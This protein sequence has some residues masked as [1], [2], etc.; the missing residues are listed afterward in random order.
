VFL[1][2]GIIVCWIKLI[3]V[4]LFALVLRIDLRG[5]TCILAIMKKD[6]ANTKICSSSF[7]ERAIHS[8]LS[9]NARTDIN[10]WS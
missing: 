3:C 8:V 4:R 5:L 6:E 7:L 1:A 9:M 10:I 2:S